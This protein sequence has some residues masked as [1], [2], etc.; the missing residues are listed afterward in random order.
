MLRQLNQGLIPEKAIPTILLVPKTR[1][2]GYS[3]H[4]CFLTFSAPLRLCA[5]M[6]FQRTRKIRVE[7]FSK[8]TSHN[9]SPAEACLRP[10]DRQ[11]QRRGGKKRTIIRIANCRAKPSIRRLCTMKGFSEDA[12]IKI[13]SVSEQQQYSSFSR[14]LVALV[15]AAKI[16]NR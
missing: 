14:P 11:A 1:K 13:E 10:K 9:H 8:T 5:M 16:A 15:Q 4:S 3:L 12:R 6:A 2:T 7:P